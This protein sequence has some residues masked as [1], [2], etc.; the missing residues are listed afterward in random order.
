MTVL[1]EINSRGLANG[2]HAE[3]LEKEA[4][5]GGETMADCFARRASVS[6]ALSVPALAIRATSAWI[7]YRFRDGSLSRYP[8]TRA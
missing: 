3:A 5:R 4:K 7:F 6:Y 1:D 8:N 2:W